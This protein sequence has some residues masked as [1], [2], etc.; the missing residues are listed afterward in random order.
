MPK[1]RPILDIDMDH[2]AVDFAKGTTKWRKRHPEEQFPH[3]HLD[4]WIDLE[5]MPGFMEAH[6][7]LIEIFD[8]RFLTAPSIRNNC[9]WTGK[10]MWLQRHFGEQY[11]KELTITSYKNRFSGFA[12]VDDGVDHGQPEYGGE[13]LHF[14]HDER[15]LNWSDVA[16]YL[17]N[18]YNESEG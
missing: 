3:S 2:C 12:L 4:F 17:I 5:P 13:H 7:R 1:S 10:A 8:V 6:K 18:K 16:D 15:F 9:C 14:G 11:L